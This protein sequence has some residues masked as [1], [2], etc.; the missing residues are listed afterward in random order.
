MKRFMRN[1]PGR[2]VS[3]IRSLGM[4]TDLGGVDIELFDVATPNT[5]QNFMNYVLDGDYEGTFIHRTVPGFVVQM[6][7]FAFDSSQGLFTDNS[8]V[9]H[10]LTDPPVVNEPGISN[11]RGTITMAKLAGD[12]DSATS[13]FFFNLADNSANL[14]TQNGGF[15]VFGQV[16]GNGM[17]VIDAVAMLERCVDIGF[18]LPRPCN[19]LPNVPLV[20]IEADNGGIFTTPVEQ[21]N[22]VN[23]LNIG[24]DGDGDGIIDTVEDGAPNSGDGNND[25]FADKT[26]SAVA[27]FLTQSNGYVTL[28]T[29]APVNILGTDVLGTTF[30]FTTIDPFDPNNALAGFSILQG[31]FGTTLTG[32]SPAGSATTM[33]VTLPATDVP[34]NFLVYGP[35]PSDTTPHWYP[36]IDD[37]TTGAVLSGNTVTLKYV[38]GER[39]DAD[40]AANGVIVVSPG[41][42]IRN[43]GDND[44]ISDLIEDGAPNNGDG[45]NDT[46]PDRNQ[47]HVVSL[48]DLRGNYLTLETSPQHTLRGVAFSQAA[49][50]LT[51]LDAGGN[52]IPNPDIPPG[53]QAGVNFAHDF[54]RFE[55]GNLAQTSTDVKIILPVGEAPIGFIKYG[56]T[57]ADPTDHVYDFTF[58]PATN[59]GA[60]Y[61]GNVV[62]L[63]LVDGGRGDSD[64]IA[65]GVIMD[66]GAVALPIS[67]AS[68]SGG[69][70]G[71]RL[72]GAASSARQGGA[73]WLL[74]GLIFLRVAWYYRRRSQ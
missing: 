38:D 63:H 55:V 30:A 67:I 73:W 51:A 17:D 69:G 15:T 23:I 27:S 43:P 62:T 74:M 46:V 61:S 70:G 60:E 21:V 3:V 33:T 18:N 26:Q 49:P 10:I 28:Q 56:P 32:I 39:G 13:E 19:L 12:P 1:R 48:P 58:D 16:L 71:C 59:T 7:G 40:L 20:G 41:G 66:P 47:D 2:Y 37:G 36:F 45:N 24:V 4:Q 52:V 65:N 34:D 64:L 9:F 14:D 42:P 11:T 44:G 25:T 6:G 68:P 57:S 22:L 72:H 29:T 8:G 31:F 5:V 50:I 53:L 54:L 35:T